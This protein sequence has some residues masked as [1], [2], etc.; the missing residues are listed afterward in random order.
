[1]GTTTRLVIKTEAEKLFLEQKAELLAIEKALVD[2][3]LI[4]C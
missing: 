1:M 4:E 3:P 2:G